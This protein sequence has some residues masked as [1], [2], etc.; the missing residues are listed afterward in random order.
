MSKTKL[1][2]IL[3][4]DKPSGMTSH[5]A[6]Q[7]IRKLA[8]QRRVGHTGT[9]DP[10]ATG[11]LVVCIGNATKIA[12]FISEMDKTYEA[13]VCLG[14][15]SETYDSEGV[16]EEQHAA[17]VPALDRTE[18]EQMLSGFLGLISQ[19]VPAYSAVR[20]DGKRLYKLARS[21][22]AVDTPEREIEI[23]DI[24]L[25]SYDRPYMEL[26]VTCSKG[27]YV[28]SLAHE[29]GA[30]LGCGGYLSRLRRTRVG[31]LTV[32]GALTL[33]QVAG[34]SSAGTL[35]EQ[36]LPCDQVLDYAA[37]LIRDEFKEHVVSGREPRKEDIFDVEGVF[38]TG[39]RVFLKDTKGLVMAVGTAGVS[40][41]NIDRS[42]VD[43]TLFNYIRVL[44]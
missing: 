10:L 26:E 1:N 24:K 41:D 42:G 13:Q 16:T 32:D 43:N 21:G 44:N 40:S 8:G 18:L 39:D 22:V 15:S 20:V 11:L 9:L 19:K 4:I 33:D 36:L 37:I 5:D 34:Y 14:R 3:L 31:R 30:K 12:R 7:Q 29:I 35:A 38:A 27:T 23:T 17:E 6:V 25:S 2:G 28:R